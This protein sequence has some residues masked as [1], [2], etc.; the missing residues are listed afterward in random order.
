MP[1]LEGLVPSAAGRC[2]WWLIQGGVGVGVGVG[3][4]VR[5]RG[6]VW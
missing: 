1:S 2:W 3:V 5:G 4:R 6:R